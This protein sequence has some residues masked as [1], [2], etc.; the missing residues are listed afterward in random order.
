MGSYTVVG[1][2]I[3]HHSPWQFQECAWRGYDLDVVVAEALLPSY[4]VRDELMEEV[5]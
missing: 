1:E 5:V 3:R 2:M 4:K